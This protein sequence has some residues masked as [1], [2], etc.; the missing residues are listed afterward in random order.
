V[1]VQYWKDPRLSWEPEAFDGV[2]SVRI[3]ASR[4]WVP[5][6][7]LY[8]ASVY[9]CCMSSH[10]TARAFLSGLYIRPLIIIF[11]LTVMNQI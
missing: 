5:D 2:D 6:I 7:Q 9:I 10:C 4:I 11:A 1:F 8:G 3:R